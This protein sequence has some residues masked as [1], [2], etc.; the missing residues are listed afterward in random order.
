MGDDRLRSTP[1]HIGDHALWVVL[2]RWL[3]PYALLAA[4]TFLVGAIAGAGAMATTSPETLVGATET[5]GNPDLFPERLTTWT[6]F[7]NNVVALAVITVGV[8]SFGLPAFV[9][10]FFN[11]LIA[12]VIV[13]V[14]A[15]QGRLLTTFAL[16]LPHGVVELSAFFVVGGVTYRV[17]WRLVSYLRGVDEQPI[18]RREAIE[19]VALVLVSVLAIAVAAWIEATLTVDIARAVVG[20]DA[21]SR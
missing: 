17:T 3:Y 21:V 6:I 14:S 20:N 8:V 11:G 1:E 7:K 15:S 5:F 19:A 18:T 2:S 13:Y 16:I 4:V 9:G 12:G 10:L